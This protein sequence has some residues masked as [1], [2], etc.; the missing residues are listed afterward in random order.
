[1][2]SER[3]G[4]RLQVLTLAGIPLQVMQFSIGLASVCA[5]EQRVWVSTHGGVGPDAHRVHELLLAPYP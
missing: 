4:E 5:D 3:V 1:M 2:V